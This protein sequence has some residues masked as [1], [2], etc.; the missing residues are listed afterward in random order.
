MEREMPRA[1]IDGPS[2]WR[3]QAIVS[4]HMVL[5]FIAVDASAHASSQSIIRV[6]GPSDNAL[7]LRRALCAGRVVARSDCSFTIYTQ[8]DAI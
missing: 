2:G 5:L 7:T 1:G 4:L 6:S 8:W 3:P